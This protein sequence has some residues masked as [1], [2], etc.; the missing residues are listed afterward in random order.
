MAIDIV[1]GIDLT[2]SDVR[3]SILVNLE[4][5]FQ[6]AGIT[7]YHSFVADLTDS[8]SLLSDSTYETI[9]ADVP[10]TGSGTWARTPEQLYFF[11][12]KRIEYYAELQKKILC[13]VIPK[14]RAGGR[15]VYISCSVFKKENE[16]VAGFIEQQF[17]LELIHMQ[18][19]HGYEMKADS[20]FVA[21]FE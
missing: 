11:D 16:A 13:N 15:L 4:R 1:P 20:M 3:K 18:L 8:Q 6:K 14:L 19:L 12:E 5:R 9:I 10:C 21:L 7:G 17:D 2:V